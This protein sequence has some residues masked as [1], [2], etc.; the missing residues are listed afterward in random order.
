MKVKENETQQSQQSQKTPFQNGF[1]K[2]GS[3]PPSPV[4]KLGH[5]CIY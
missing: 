2:K 5:Y 1:V 3:A 4:D